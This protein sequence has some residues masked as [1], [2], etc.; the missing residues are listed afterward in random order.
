MEH[1]YLEI[2][3]PPR[4]RPDTVPVDAMI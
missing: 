3:V 4:L 1:M 2:R